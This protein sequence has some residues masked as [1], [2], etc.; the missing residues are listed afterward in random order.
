M[1]LQIV[2]SSFENIASVIIRQVKMYG[3]LT[4]H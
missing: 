4:K 2:Y 1:A 3:L